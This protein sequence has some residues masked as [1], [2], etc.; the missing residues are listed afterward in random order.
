MDEVRIRR[1]L[2]AAGTVESDR[3]EGQARAGLIGNP[4]KSGFEDQDPEARVQDR[5]AE[6][7]GE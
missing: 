2:Q 7:R 5:Q 1:L 6:D 4:E 3:I